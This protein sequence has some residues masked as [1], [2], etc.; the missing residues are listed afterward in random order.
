MLKTDHQQNIEKDTIAA[1]TKFEY[2]LEPGDKFRI[3]IYPN[4]GYQLADILS[5]TTTARVDIDYTIKGNGYVLLPVI[6]SFHLAGMTIS[7]AELA[8]RPYYSTYFINPFIKIEMANRRVTVIK[9]R[10]ASTVVDLGNENMNLL[11]VLAKAGGLSDQNRSMRVKIVRGDLNNPI[12]K[13]VDLS[14]ISTMSQED[15]RVFPNDI[16]YVE[17]QF[18]FTVVETQVVPLLSIVT[19]LFLVYSILKSVK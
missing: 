7:Q 18:S 1:K 17:P 5:V 11:E 4:K 19:S 6:D 12:V 13:F 9:A 15:L 8:L 2:L 3:Y 14:H 16:I 10:A